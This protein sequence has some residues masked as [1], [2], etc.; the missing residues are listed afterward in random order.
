MFKHIASNWSLHI[1]QIV[2]M[3][4]LVPL[5][6][7]ELGK[8]GYGIWVAII[9]A[10]G[11]LELLAL[12]VP[13]AAVRHVSEALA[14]DDQDLTNRVIATGLGVTMGLGVLG[15]A[16]GALLFWPFQSEL[17]ESEHW[18]GTTPEMLA[19]AQ[20]AYAITA[21]RVAASLAL[22]FP[23]AVFDAH[24]DFVTKNAVLGVSVLL[25]TV[26]VIVLLKTAP[27]LEGLACIFAVDALVLFLG[28]RYW[29]GRRFEGIRF[30]LGDFDS[31]LVRELM[32]FGIFAALLNVGSLVAYQLDTLV[33]GY[34]IGPGPITEFEIGNKFFL[35][36]CGLMFGLGAVVMPTSTALKAAGK[37]QALGQV[38]LKWSKVSLSVIL[39]VCLFLIVL[40][41]AFLGAW[42]KPEYRELSGPVT[43]ILAPSFLLYLPVRAVALPI[44]L[45]TSRP[46]RAATVFL[47]M[48]IVNL[49]LS[50]GLV[51]AGYGIVGVALGTA[52]PQ[53]FYAAYLLK[54]TCTHLQV[55][56]GSWLRYVGG[57]ATLGS[58][59]PIGLLLWF[60]YG[61]GVS[62]F[63][64]LVGAGVA[65]VALYSAIWVLFVYR[66]DR[67]LDLREEIL[68]RLPGGRT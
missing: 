50:I 4:V 43:R 54:I 57:R 46:G 49:S 15:A 40:G 17:L 27:S 12:G 67:F 47:A 58:L 61:L 62:S 63:A 18:A 1:L 16:L 20:L 24:R 22:R 36:L 25:R 14:A 44:L 60:E 11:F 42:V 26:A 53:V 5:L 7:E 38:F 56:V 34:F 48:S 30:G 35:P 66:D 51:Q 8:D 64:G 6:E 39:P 3:L 10:T 59:P 19:G 23:T 41:P 13:M 31:K 29:I 9:A 21:L 37:D 68:L 45:G 28:L 55:P 52:I 2:I 32:G 65:T 33:I